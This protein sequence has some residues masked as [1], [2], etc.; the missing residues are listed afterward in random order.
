VGSLDGRAAVIAAISVAVGDGKMAVGI[1]F[2]NAAVVGRGNNGTALESSND[3]IG[4]IADA[5]S[6][7]SRNI[8]QVGPGGRN[9]GAS[10][11]DAADIANEGDGAAVNGAVQG[12]FGLGTETG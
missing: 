7:G 3:G 4:G 1:H 12:Q 8:E 11:A 9:R 6:V 10:A 2:G 5:W